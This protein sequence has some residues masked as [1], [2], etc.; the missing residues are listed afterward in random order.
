VNDR[1]VSVLENYDMEVTR[2]FKGRGTIICETGKGLR[3]LKEYNGN[4]EKLEVLELLQGKLNETVRTDRLVR[5]KEGELFCK[6]TDGTAYI[7][8]EQLDGRECNYKNEEEILQAFR[9]MAK[10]HQGMR[11]T[12]E[13]ISAFPVHYYVEEMEKHTKECKHA[14]NYLRK[15]KIK[16]DFE[17]ALLKEYTYFM[18]KAEDIMKRA[19]EENRSEYEEFVRTN[20]FFCHGDYQYHNVLFMKN[21]IAVINLEHF[22]LDSG[23]RDFYLLFRKISEKA[24]WSLSLGEKMLNAYQSNRTLTPIEQKQLY[25]RLAYPDKFWKIVN[26]YY[27]SKKSWIPDKNMEKLENLVSQ[28]KAKE[29]LLRTLFD[30]V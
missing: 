21:D 17:R 15:V 29:K 13:R 30:F 19:A 6:D 26:F 24:D 27:N 2:T 11:Y 8:K 12:G 7:V 18:E 9:V 16:S 4:T 28:E 23:V 22:A 1:A 3:V 5:N 20:G 10:L 14:R 25:Y